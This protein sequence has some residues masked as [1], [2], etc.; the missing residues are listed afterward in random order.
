MNKTISINIG[1]AIFNIEE[2]AFE[3]LHQYL[4]QI[5]LNFVGDASVTEIM[6]D[7]E[8]RIAELFA[9]RMDERKNAIVLKDVEEV[10]A[11]MGQPEDYGDAG[12]HAGAR[13][14]EKSSQQTGF[15]GDGVRHDRR[16]VYRDED[17]AYVGGVCSGLSY[18]LGWDPMILR[19]AFV[20][21]AL[22][23]GSAVLVYIVFW[24]VLPVARTTAEKL[25]MR[26]E[27]VNI[28]NIS[29]FVN[30][31]AEKA[32]R[33]I[34]K[35]GSKFRNS[36]NSRNTSEFGHVVK[37][38]VGALLIFFAL[39]ALIGLLTGGFIAQLNLFGAGGDI[40]KLNQLIF[41]DEST[42][43]LIIFGGIL[44][45]LIP[46][47]GMLVAGVRLLVDSTKRIR[48]IGW[49][50]LVIFVIGMVMIGMG[51]SSAFREFRSHGQISQTVALDSLTSDTLVVMVNADTIFTGREADENYEFFELVNQNESQVIYGDNVTFHVEIADSPTLEVVRMCQGR[52]VIEAGQ[53]AERMQYD[54]SVNGNTITLDPL[55]S[56]P[57]N[58]PYR[59]QH[60]DVILSLPEG[61]KVRFNRNIDYLTW[62]D[63]YANNVLMATEDGLE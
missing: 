6:A 2:D 3:K 39:S 15:T 9:Q 43:W 62:H 24:A 36:M 14:E 28:D 49:S 56:T 37:K 10:I 31:E 29:R 1:G 58:D 12:A 46:L 57:G 11:I 8:G 17:D 53:R 45:I 41:Q 34:N 13:N 51:G 4:E 18:Y 30:Q 60:V 23:G 21:L 33:N 44:V 25:R 50:F 42:I 48:G 5:K 22:V 54:F 59:G 7:I 32:A 61:M 16:R 63:E 55:V 26:G 27:P 40:N 20:V 38:I 19:L 52:N 35:A 47:L